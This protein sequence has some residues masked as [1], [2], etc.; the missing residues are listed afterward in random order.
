MAVFPGMP[1]PAG[2]TARTRYSSSTLLGC[3]VSVFS[4]AR[5]MV[6]HGDGEKRAGYKNFRVFRVFRGPPCV[7]PWLNP[8]HFLPRAAFGPQKLVGPSFCWGGPGV[9][10][11]SETYL[12]MSAVRRA[13]TSGCLS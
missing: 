9:L 1:G 11:P 13:T 6:R 7:S 3:P 5:D 10:R 8:I 12:S 2:L 4:E